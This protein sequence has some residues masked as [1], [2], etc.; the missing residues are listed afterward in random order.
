MLDAGLHMWVG[1][2]SDNFY[3]GL[4][5]GLLLGGRLGPQ[6]SGNAELVIDLLNPDT[7]EGVSITEFFFDLTFSPLLHAPLSPTTQF[8]LG[9]KLGVFMLAESASAQGESATVWGWGWVVGANAGIVASQGSTRLGVLTSFT[10]RNPLKVCIDTATSGEQC[11]S[12]NFRAGKMLS[13]A[14]L[15]ML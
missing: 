13:L 15:I 8:V 3:P 1:Q 9:P 10:A 2:G 4:R 7:P 6:V 5:T 11:V 12:E 14:F